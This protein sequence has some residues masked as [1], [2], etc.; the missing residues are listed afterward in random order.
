[1]IINGRGS[2][3]SCSRRLNFRWRPAGRSRAALGLG[4]AAAL[5]LAAGCGSSAGSGSGG[6]A[7]QHVHLTYALWDPVQEVGYKK[8]IALFEK[9]HPNISITVEQIPYPDYEAKLT[10]EFTSGAGPDVFCV[11]TPFLAQFEQANVMLNLAPLIKKS[12][13]NMSVYRPA[14]VALHSHNGAIYGLPKDWDTEGIFYNKTYFARHH[15]KIPASLTWNP[16][17][18]GS[19]LTL[20]REATTDK[21]GTSAL[22][23]KFSPAAIATYGVSVINQPD[24]GYGPF[25]A[26]AGV[27]VFEQASLAGGVKCS[28]YP[29]SVT[30]N[31]PAGVSAMQFIV[32]M[33]LKYHV[34]PPASEYGANG[35]APTNQDVTLFARGKTAM[36]VEGDWFTSTIA[37]TA[38]FKF[39]V[40]PLPAG[41]D[42][43]WSFTNGL[44]DAV[45]A[46]TPHEAA[47]WELEQWLGSATSESIMGSGGYVWPGIASLDGTFLSYWKNKGV[48]V[49][50]FLDAAE[51]SSHLETLPVSQQA[52]QVI[53]SLS[54]DLGPAFLGSEPVA[55]AMA[56]AAKDGTQQLQNP[57]Q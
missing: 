19:F 17:T 49:S 14:L 30:F 6:S 12:H 28:C 25:L 7:G 53:T 15:I 48:D 34:A 10:S 37:S 47:A 8:S 43:R 57:S 46:R 41:P 36:A 22:S 45:N 51:D 26:S 40:L 38:K 32:N 2:A 42:G 4:L 20:A 21:N 55:S 54:A 24:I 5:A 11:N 13:L 29:K 18:G 1:M 56:K 39:G 33:A 35:A 27:P 50:P 31:T 52:G 44:I 9:S 3:V 23:P 16:T